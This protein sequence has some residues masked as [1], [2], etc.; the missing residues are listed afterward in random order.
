[1]AFSSSEN[2]SPTII[3]VNIA[4]ATVTVSLN[5]L[6]NGWVDSEKYLILLVL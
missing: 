4:L 3:K 5:A 6:N 1:M 2:S